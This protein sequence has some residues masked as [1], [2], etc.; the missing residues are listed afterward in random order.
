MPETVRVAFV[1]CTHPHIFARLQ[2]LREWQI[3]A[4]GCYDPDSTLTAALE[5]DCGLKAYASPEAV[6]DQPGVNWVIIEG[7]DPDNARYVQAALERGQ[8]ILLEKPGAPN[9]PAIH[10]L[11]DAVKSAKSVPFQIGYMLPYGSA[12]AHARRILDE[13]V[14]GPVTL[15]RFHGATPV[16]GSRE[17]WQSVPGNL[18]GLMYTDACHLVH[19]IVRLL[20]MPV[21]VRGKILRLPEGE[22]V[23]AHGFKKDT[24]S[25]LG[26][27]VE[28]PIGGLVYED[29]GAAVFDY[30]D[31]LVTMDLTGWEA[32]PWVEAWRIELYG[33]NG[34]LH[35]GLQPPWY[36][37]YVRNPK[38]GYEPGWHNWEGFGVSGVGTSL[39]V[40]ENYTNEMRH[41]L[42]R[43]QSWDT[44]NTRS[45][46]EAEAVITLLSAIYDSDRSG[47]AIRVSLR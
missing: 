15:A 34:T 30:G 1:G 35:V 39:L 5:R 20:G 25:G 4:V 6:L 2:L 28:M 29:V 19:I 31:K 27:T 37:L 45:L 36:K 38:A 33:A 16:G 13:G 22:P 11:V 18:G 12:M 46:M 14:L 7:W 17:I 40:D 9:L 23:I 3:E 43:V 21:E 26:D 24:L 47:S 44:D 10:A 32:H 42:E 8:A 41:M